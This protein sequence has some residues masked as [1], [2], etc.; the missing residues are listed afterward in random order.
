MVVYNTAFDNRNLWP[1]DYEGRFVAKVGKMKRVNTG[2]YQVPVS[3]GDR[4]TGKKYARTGT[5]RENTGQS[6]AYYGYNS[7]SG[8][9]RRILI[10]WNGQIIDLDE[11]LSIDEGSWR[12]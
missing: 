3:I 6:P 8:L 4:L 1:L 5:I 9:F 12:L 7:G 2:V 11:L 10:R